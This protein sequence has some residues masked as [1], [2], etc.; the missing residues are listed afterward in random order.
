M[1]THKGKFAPINPKKYMGNPKN[2]IYRSWWEFCYFR[3]LDS[4]KNV[5]RWASEE[6][7]IRYVSPIDNKIHRYF[8]DVYYETAKG[9]KYLIEIK[10]LSQSVPP[11]IDKKKNRRKLLSEIKTYEVNQSKWKAAKA[12]CDERNISFKVLTEKQ[13]NL[14]DPPKRKRKLGRN[15][16]K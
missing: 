12:W 8:P 4:D 6:F 15:A 16:F 13:L 14:I 2:I 11:K 9:E 7:C 5:V 10:P 3:Q 1:A